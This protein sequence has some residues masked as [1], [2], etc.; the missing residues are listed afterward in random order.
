MMPDAGPRTGEAAGPCAP[1]QRR[2]ETETGDWERQAVFRILLQEARD[3]VAGEVGYH[4]VRLRLSDL[5]QVGREIGR[6]GR[7][8]LIGRE[9]PAIA[10]HETLRDLQQVMAERIIGGE[11]IPL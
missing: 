5:E 9:L 10:F 3:L 4:Q 1:C 6:I 2:V 8:K 7:H 11:R